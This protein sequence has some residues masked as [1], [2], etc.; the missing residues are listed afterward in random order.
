VTVPPRVGVIDYGMGNRRSVQKAIE[1]AGAKVVVTGDRGEL[2]ACDGLVLPGVGAFPLAMRRLRERGLDELIRADVNRGVP[3]IGICLG[4][5]LLFEHS[6]EL[7]PSEGLGVLP[8]EVRWLRTGGLR[9]PHIG[10][11]DVAFE[12]PSHLTH[13]LPAAGCPFYHVHSLAVRAADPHDV[14]GSAEYG[15][16]FP[17]IVG[18]G[19]VFGVQFHP[20]KSSKHGLQMLGAF[21]ELCSSHHSDGSARAAA[22]G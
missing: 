21:V 13:G 19:R 20:E 10:W 4:M 16:R 17:A 1:R 11:S 22:G 6:E 8:G 15:Q 9:L 18:R 5:Q 7:E 14:L 3:L 2:D 12:Q